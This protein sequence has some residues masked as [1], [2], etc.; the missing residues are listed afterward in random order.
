MGSVWCRAGVL[1]VLAGLASAAHAVI[2]AG[3]DGTQNTTGDG[4]PGWAHVGSVNGATGVYLGN[5]WVLTAAHVNAGTLNLPGLGNFT[6]IPDSVF[7]LVD[8]VTSAPTDMTMFRISGDPGLPTLTIAPFAPTQ[9]RGVFM[10]GYGRNRAPAQLYWS[11][12]TSNPS[13]WV[14][15][16]LSSP[17]GANASG[18]AYGPGHT[19]RWGSNVIDN[20]P[21]SGDVTGIINAGFGD[22]RVFTTYFTNISGEGQ[23]APGDSGGAVFDAGGRLLGLMVAIGGY[24][25]QPPETAVFGMAT[26]AADLFQYRNQIAVR[27]NVV[28]EP[29]GLVLLLPVL[30]LAGRR[31]RR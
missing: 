4:V 3:G 13:N 14:W 8:P 5:G 10:I 6:H 16:Q 21:G 31:C 27:I 19:K 28:P 18:Y 23:G 22:V 25:N 24:P 29:A 20:F 26:Y 11:V 1:G 7:R 17:T 2:V 30:T 15:T 12:N 9:G